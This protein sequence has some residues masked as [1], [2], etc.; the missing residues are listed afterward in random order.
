MYITEKSLEED[1]FFDLVVEDEDFAD[2]VK[3]TL[4]SDNKMLEDKLSNLDSLKN[5]VGVSYKNGKMK[6]FDGDV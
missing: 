4:Q 2:F 6:L 3:N 1:N 5:D